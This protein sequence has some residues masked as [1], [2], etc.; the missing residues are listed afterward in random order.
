VNVSVIYVFVI[1]HS[2]IFY[3]KFAGCKIIHL[4]IFAIELDEA[5]NVDV[6]LDVCTFGAHVGQ[7]VGKKEH[8]T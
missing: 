1:S 6:N 7:L 4:C 5:C 2:L 8:D 3:I